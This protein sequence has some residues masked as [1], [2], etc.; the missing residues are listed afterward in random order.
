MKGLVTVTYSV[1][2]FQWQETLIFW[3]TVLTLFFCNSATTDEHNKQEPLQE[4]SQ[5]DKEAKPDIEGDNK[6][7][8]ELVTSLHQKQQTTSLEV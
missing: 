1:I 5:G 4:N 6:Q 3:A 8:R 2:V 7:L